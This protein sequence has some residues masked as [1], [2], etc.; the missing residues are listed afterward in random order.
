[1]ITKTCFSRRRQHR[2]PGLVTVGLC[3][4][5]YQNVSTNQCGDREQTTQDDRLNEA[6][7]RVP[8]S[9]AST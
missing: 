3:R 1:M 2:R 9:P 7:A 6:N 4:D 8:P 5:L